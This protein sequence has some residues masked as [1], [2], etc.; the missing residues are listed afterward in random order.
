MGEGGAGFKPAAAPADA[1]SSRASLA[2]AAGMRRYG[3]AAI[4]RGQDME[5]NAKSLA[6]LPDHATVRAMT[7]LEFI[8]AIRD[9]RLPRA[10]IAETLDFDMVEVEKGRVVFAGEAKFAAYNPIGTVHGG[11]FGTLLDSC[12]ACAVQTM[13]PAGRGY[14]TLEYKVNILRAAT[15]ES[16]RLRAEGRAVHVGR[17]TATAEGRMTDAKGK[18]YA[19]AT[20]TCIVLEL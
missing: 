18:L 4:D 6:E 16:G 12:M 7:G 8:E 13:L 14:T 19:T 20:T 9:G 5:L 10:P 17:R 11:W 15:V 1:A 2:S 3:A